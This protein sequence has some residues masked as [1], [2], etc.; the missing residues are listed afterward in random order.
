MM[1]RGRFRVEAGGN[2]S[3][4]IAPGQLSENHADELLSAT[5][6]ADTG[7]RIVA[8]DQPGKRLPMDPIENLR[9]NVA[10]SIHGPNDSQNRSRSSNPS[11]RNLS[12]MLSFFAIYKN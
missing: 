6:V 12:V 9:E 11:H 1:Q 8:L 2:I 10:A 5:K 3:E 7:L 4:S